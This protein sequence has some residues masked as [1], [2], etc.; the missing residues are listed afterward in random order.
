MRHIQVQVVFVKLYLLSVV[1]KLRHAFST[2]DEESMAVKTYL[3]LWQRT[4]VLHDHKFVAV[5]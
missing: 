4:E 5:A 3:A 2:D 1:V